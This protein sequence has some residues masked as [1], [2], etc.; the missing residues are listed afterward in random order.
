MSKLKYELVTVEFLQNKNKQFGEVK[1]RGR[2]KGTKKY[3]LFHL[4]QKNSTEV[5]IYVSNEDGYIKEG[6][7]VEE[8]IKLNDP[9]INKKLKIYEKLDFVA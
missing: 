3:R 2:I 7:T 5:I 8:K 1:W 6:A 4:P 9:D